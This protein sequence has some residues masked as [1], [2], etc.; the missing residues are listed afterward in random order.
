[1][2][3]LSRLLLHFKKAFGIVLHLSSLSGTTLFVRLPPPLQVILVFR[4]AR[5][6]RKKES[7]QR[8]RGLPAKTMAR[9]RR[10]KRNER[11][12][13]VVATAAAVVMESLGTVETDSTI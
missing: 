10:N 7:R 3:L 12:A 1:L 2:Q 5:R 6:K 4:P 9:G 13:A 11:R 8:E